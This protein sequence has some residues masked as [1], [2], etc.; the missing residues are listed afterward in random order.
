M[1]Y[2]VPPSSRSRTTMKVA[3]MN[4]GAASAAMR[5]ARPCTYRTLAIAQKSSAPHCI[6]RSQTTCQARVASI[7]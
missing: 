7:A 6:R 4:N 3:S 2:E 5:A 1:P